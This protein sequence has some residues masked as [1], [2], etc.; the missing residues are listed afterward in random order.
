MKNHLKLKLGT[1]NIFFEKCYNE[2]FIGVGYDMD[3]DFKGKFPEKWK[4]FNKKYIPEYIERHPGASKIAA[5]LA[6]ATIWVVSNYLQVGDIVICPNK[7]NGFSIAE[8]TGDYFYHES[9]IFPHRRPVTWLNLEINPENLSEALLS[10]L[11]SRGTY[12]DITKHAEEI[13]RLIGGQSAPKII[14]TD[15]EIE[16]PTAFALEKHLEEFLVQNWSKTEIG[17]DYDIFEEG[18]SFGQQYPTDTGPLDIL[19]ISK[20]KKT[21]LIIELKKGKASDRV[22]G[23]IQR[24]MG[25]VKEELAEKD[26]QVKG[27]IIALEDDKRVRR[28]LSVASD[29]EFYRY[30]VRFKLR[31]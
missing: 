4:D 11:N 29:I 9:E 27:V 22:V 14:S 19:A 10:S 28:A 30:E 8:I 12:C 17:K 5:G 21:L 25:F 13:A 15:K 18:E 31:K 20:D 23:Q 16:D 6:C 7:N 26:Q 3:I 24:Y 1:K 2:K